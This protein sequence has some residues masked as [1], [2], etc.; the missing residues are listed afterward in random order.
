MPDT[1][2]GRRYGYWTQ[3]W[4][5]SVDL[6]AAGDWVAAMPRE[7]GEWRL[8]ADRPMPEEIL[9]TL[10]CAGHVHRTYV[11]QGTGVEVN[12]AL[13]VGP[14][15]PTSVHTP[16]ICYSS[17]AHEIAEPRKVWWFKPAGGLAHSFWSLTFRSRNAGSEALRVYYA[18]SRGDE[19]VASASPRFEFG[20][21]PQL[22][23]IQVSTQFDPTGQDESSDPCRSFVD[24]LLQTFWNSPHA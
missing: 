23:K 13:I 16:E 20:G 17:R 1:G 7:V 3:R 4:G 12:V 14:P 9:K 22:Y 6:Q 18:W 11:H 24:A 5:P 15:G 19:W 2:D 10:E 8:V 21:A